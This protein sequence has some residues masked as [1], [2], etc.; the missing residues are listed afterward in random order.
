MFMAKK[1]TKSRSKSRKSSGG[2]GGAFL[3]FILLVAA[4]AWGSW[5]TWIWYKDRGTANGEGFVLPIPSSNSQK[6]KT[7]EKPAASGGESTR[8]IQR[9]K[10]ANRLLEQEKASLERDVRDLQ[11]EL[12]RLK[13]E[14]DNLMVK[15]KIL[16]NEA[17]R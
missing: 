13:E 14:R 6:D 3:L 15:N 4:C 9:L 12:Q 2:G 1:K 8:E 17:K 11:K 16:Q 5:M 7:V 10:D